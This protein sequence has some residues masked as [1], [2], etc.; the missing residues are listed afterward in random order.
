MG[1]GHVSLVLAQTVREYE[2]LTGLQLLL[3]L[4]P[5]PENV[6]IRDSRRDVDISSEGL[7]LQKL[8]YLENLSTCIII[9]MSVA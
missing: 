9:I 6:N 7:F 8:Y 3:V 1:N 4:V 2:M 5:P